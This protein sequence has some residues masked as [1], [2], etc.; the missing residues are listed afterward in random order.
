MTTQ[1][2]IARPNLSALER[3]YL[4]DAYDSSWI[5]SKGEYIDKF[6]SSFSDYI[7]QKYAVATSNGTTAL[8]LALLALDIKPGD[9]VILPSLTFAA[10]INAVLYVGATPVIVDVSRDDWCISCDEVK[11]AIT[12]NTKA[13]IV[14]HLYGQPAN[15]DKLNHIVKENSLYL[16]EDCAEAHGAEFNG[17]K[18]GSFGD[19]SCFSFFAN[20]ILTTGEG[21]MCLTSSELLQNKMRILRDHGMDPNKRYWHNV[22]GYNYRLTNLQAAIGC[23]QVERI[24][25]IIQHRKKIYDQYSQ[26]IGD[27]KSMAIQAQIKNRK[28]VPWLINIICEDREA[29]ANIFKRLGLETRNFFY[30]LGEMPIYSKYCVA[31]CIN[32]NKL[33]ESGL[34]FSAL[35][36]PSEEKLSLLKMQLGQLRHECPVD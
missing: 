21:G 22:I 3:E 27:I 34:S 11:A 13:I 25:E 5:S 15:I 29:V 24:A 4:M 32:S 16:I 9:E 33:S 23:A 28:L 31:D 7:G 12:T 30:S 10:T 8:H 20:K 6:E 2:P 35:D 18:V 19:V 14:V 26:W 1:T 17:D 36:C